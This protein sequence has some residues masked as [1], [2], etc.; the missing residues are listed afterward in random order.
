MVA[1]RED[2]A[3]VYDSIFKRSDLEVLRKQLKQI[4]L[5]WDAHH[6]E[7]GEHILPRE[8]RFILDPAS[9]V[10]VVGTKQNQKI[11]DP[12]ATHSVRTLSAG[13][14]SGLTS[15][16]QP[17]YGFSTGDPELD[18]YQPVKEWM[19]DARR[20]VS[21]IFLRSNIYRILPRLYTAL[22]VFGTGCALLEEDDKDVI[23]AYH[24]PIGSYYLMQDERLQ[25]DGIVREFPMTVRQIERRF[26]QARMS[27]KLKAMRQL[28][29]EMAVSVVHVIRP[30][31]QHRPDRLE[32]RHKAWVSCYYEMAGEENLILG[33][34]GYDEFPGLTPRWLETDGSPY[35]S[36]PGMDALP[37]IKELQTL[38]RRKA[39]ALEKM[40][41]PP[42]VGPS[43]LKNSAVSQM[44]GRV[45]YVDEHQKG[46]G[47]RP[48]LQVNIPLQ[49]LN[50]DIDGLRKTIRSTFAEDLFLM[51][52]Q[53]DRKDITAA[54]IHA[55]QEE[56]IQAL[57]P[58]LENLQT[59]LLKPLVDRTFAIA[60]R[61][62]KFPKAPDELI[63]RSLKIEYT[64]PMAQA[65]R[66]TGLSGIRQLV[67]DVLQVAPLKPEIL[68]KVDFD[69]TVDESGLMLG[70][71][72]KMIRTDDAVAKLRA[73][74]A[75]Q[76]KAAQSAALAEQASVA[77]KNL[78]QVPADGDSMLHNI[79]PGPGNAQSA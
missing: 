59:E 6:Q 75:E 37:D 15:P 1:V 79:I 40:V 38:R 72:P 13:L 66:A 24:M 8:G 7:L 76:Q 35:G 10:N 44:A 31:P 57:G 28:Q 26:G 55:R 43:S 69:Q 36:S 74:R 67:A 47:L 33:E 77:A 46:D 5:S 73:D 49:Y 48:L 20:I 9:Q 30:N 63:G 19:S 78:A 3:D 58:V 34:S 62:G 25:V 17:W 45:N 51:L 12:T 64:S 23:R 22:G 54:E 29:S 56:R 70:V 14:M 21:D 65:A 71:P 52:A 2:I 68:D 41:R 50:D 18:E 42:L 60:A 27:T 61:R 39:E 53:S 11:L 32:S 16:S 4:R